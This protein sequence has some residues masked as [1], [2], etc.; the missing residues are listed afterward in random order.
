MI[1][2]STALAI[3]VFAT[4]NADAQRCNRWK[5]CYQQIQEQENTVLQE[6]VNTINQ[7]LLT[8][9]KLLENEKSNSFIY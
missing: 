5:T 8:Q 2:F 4:P 7:T 9:I 1:L 6:T 3:L